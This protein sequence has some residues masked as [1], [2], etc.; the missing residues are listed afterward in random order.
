MKQLMVAAAQARRRAKVKLVNLS[1][2]SFV[3]LYCAGLIV[4]IFIMVR[5]Y[6]KRNSKKESDVPKAAATK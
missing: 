2:V 4:I 3:Y 1:K 5:S 6:S